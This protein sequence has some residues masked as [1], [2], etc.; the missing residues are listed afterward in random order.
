MIFHEP[1]QIFSGERAVG[2]DAG[3][4]GPVGDFPRFADD[5]AGREF[6]AVKPFEFASAPDAFLENRLESER[7]KHCRLSGRLGNVR[8]RP[9]SIFFDEMPVRAEFF[10][11]R[12]QPFGDRQRE[13]FFEMFEQMRFQICRR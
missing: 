5:R 3:V 1:A 11:T 6:F 2:D 9:D 12:F 13:H 10:V 7:V 4:A 8:S